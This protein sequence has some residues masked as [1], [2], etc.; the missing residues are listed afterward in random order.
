MQYFGEDTIEELSAEI[1]VWR[2]SLSEL[3]AISEIGETCEEIWTYRRGLAILHL[4]LYGDHRAFLQELARS[5]QCRRY[6]LRRCAAQGY[7]DFYCSS[8]RSEPYWDALAA[9]CFELARD[10][11]GLSPVNFRE[12]EEYEDD[13]CYQRFIYQWLDGNLIATPELI[14]LIQRFEGALEGAQSPRLDI[15]KSFFERD[16][17]AFTRAFYLLLEERYAQIKRE[18][19]GIAEESVCAAAGTYVFIE[20]LG[21]LRI[22]ELAGIRIRDEYPL[23]P[24]LARLAVVGDIPADEW[25]F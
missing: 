24:L 17:E 14:S 8:S 15:C 3:S 20:G 22:A 16:E 19:F 13:Y 12:G 4:L 5:A 21:L 18:K 9:S 1:K 23:C 2:E 10:I 25:A 7:T 6:H 11:A